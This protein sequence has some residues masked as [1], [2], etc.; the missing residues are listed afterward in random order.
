M[1][2]KKSD[3]LT[4]LISIV[5]LVLLCLAFN[6]LSR[7]SFWVRENSRPH[8]E[9]FITEETAIK[10]EKKVESSKGVEAHIATSTVSVPVFVYHSVRPYVQGESKSQDAYDIT[11]ELFDEQLTYLEDN[12]YT[13]VTLDELSDLL[14]KGVKTSDTKKRVV[15]TFDDGW[16][17]QYTYA[18][19]LLKKHHMTAMFYVYT[20][21]IGYKHFLTWPQLKE[22]KQEGM[23]VGSH[24]L[25]HPFFKKS[26]ED[27]LKKEILESRLILEKE[28]NVPIKHFAS[29]F[30]YSNAHIEDVIKESGYETGR[31]I[32][33]GSLQRDPYALR[34]YLVTDSMDDFIKVL[35]GKDPYR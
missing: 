10:E 25:T 34:G 9:G 2:F 27:D 3:T 15:L 5:V 7:G 17:N 26:S 12:G 29:P 31:T 28:L 32:Y 21:P 6:K 18:Y 19:P 8:A 35:N 23:E 33:R 14:G 30:G 11:P 4:F 1:H 13:A 24:T 16:E 22:M 20:K